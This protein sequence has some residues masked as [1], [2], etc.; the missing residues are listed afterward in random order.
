MNTWSIRRKFFLLL[1][2]FILP[3]TGSIILSGVERRNHEIREA[4][5][6]ALRLVQSLSS[7]QDQIATGIRQMLVTLALLPEV[8]RMDAAACNEVFR[9]LLDRNPSCSVIGLATPD[10]NLI[11]ASP[12][13][14]P[15]S[16]S[17]SDRKHVRD[18]IQT[19]DFSA[20][21]YITGRV[22][23]VS[24]INYALPVITGNGELTGVVIA[25][26]RLDEYSRYFQKANLPD[27]SSLSIADHA[28]TR[29]FRMPQGSTIPPGRPL[30]G[31]VIQTV[32]GSLDHGIFERIGQDGIRRIYAFKQLR[33]RSDLPPYLIMSVGIP[34]DRIVRPANIQMITD[35][36]VL[37]IGAFLAA[38]AAWA[39]GHFAFI[40]PI[41]VLADAARSFGTGDMKKRT[42]LPHTPDEL[43]QLAKAFDEMASLLETRTMDHLLAEESLRK[44]HDELEVKVSERT[45]ELAEAN[46]TLRQEMNERL[47]TERR[48]RE[49][50]EQYRRF[51]ETANEG[52][53]A[54]DTELR[55]VF[56]NR[57]ICD[58]LGYS[59]QELEGKSVLDFFFEEDMPDHRARIACAQNGIDEKF[60]CRLLRKNGKPLWTII[61]AKSLLDDRGRYRGAFAMLTDITERKRM[62]KALQESEL[63]Y[64]TLFET[65]SDTISLM[66]DGIIVDCNQATLSMLGCTVMEEVIGFTPAHFSPLRQ[67]DG[68]LSGEKAAEYLAETIEGRP[69]SFYWQHIR[70][71]GTAIDVEVSLNRVALGG[72]T[73]V[74]T[75]SRDIT[76]R[77]RADEEKQKLA[78]QLRQAQKMEAIGRL[79]GGVAHDFNNMLGVILGYAELLKSKLPPGDGLLCDVMEI[80]RAGL[81][82]RD[83]TRQLLAFSRKQVVAPR[84]VEI[85]ALIDGMLKT[86][87][88]LIGEDVE[89]RF[90]PGKGAS[91]VLIDPAQVD[92]ILVNLGANARDAMPN[93]G[94]LAIETAA[95]HLDEERCAEHLGVLPGAF[96]LLT[97]TDTGVGMEK[98][99]L[100]HAFEPFFTTKDSSRGTGLGLATVY[101]IVRQN[102]GFISVHS[103]PGCGTSFKIYLPR[104]TAGAEAE[105]QENASQPPV[106]SGSGTILVVEDEEMI[107]E[108]TALILKRQGYTI[109]KASNP[110]EAL[111]M[112]KNG[113][114][115]VDLLLTDV[116]MPGMS[117]KELADRLL[118]MRPDIKV[119]FMSGYTSNVVVNRGVLEDGL[120]FLPKPFSIADL[121]RKVATVLNSG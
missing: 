42:G 98:E 100:Q 102:G 67:P 31:E 60:E 15:G 82:S 8:Q 13:F 23:N 36:F 62:E 4:E 109:R 21:E 53:W 94:T 30:S 18:A 108:M 88:K 68:R 19:L 3:C 95:V 32:T 78:E 56:V 57:I 105:E 84:K 45:A 117:G 17:L 61:S 28:G 110:K 9:K 49:S 76:E 65:A 1:L 58:L 73:Y 90:L 75:I 41:S 97:V 27:D 40:R 114:L 22:S 106:P 66:E 92:Q 25:G 2:L 38:I 71:D 52:V 50:E 91:P 121:C 113:E 87:S 111:E 43:G 54:I 99:L 85:N 6:N 39:T 29:L 70:R 103:E 89:L 24:S 59:R 44:T 7:V 20:G 77:K 81:R 51:I 86:L 118:Q 37:G 35:L 63:K 46:R 112:C 79:A 34:K 119:L 5:A 96:V 104:F 48:L 12:A 47:L 14:T 116:I 101:G 115:R 120:N 74:Q 16:I 83:I 26:F 69:Q 10:G 55:I 93:G 80:E 72:K 64:R 33:L 107:R 11:A